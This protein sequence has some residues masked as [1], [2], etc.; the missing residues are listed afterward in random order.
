[1]RARTPVLSGE[2]DVVSNYFPSYRILRDLS[3]ER[4]KAELSPNG[5]GALESLLPGDF[6]GD[7]VVDGIDLATLLAAW[8]G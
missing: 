6:N 1:M 3:S 4:M 2:K 5:A 8:G 7:G